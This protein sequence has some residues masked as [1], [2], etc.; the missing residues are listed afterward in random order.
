M[1]VDELINQLQGFDGSIE[2]RLRNPYEPITHELKRA[3]LKH[4]DLF[5]TYIELN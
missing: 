4:K 2:V 1:T 5:N 3:E